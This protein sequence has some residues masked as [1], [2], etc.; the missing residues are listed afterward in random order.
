MEHVEIDWSP[1]NETGPVSPR[2]KFWIDELLDAMERAGRPMRVDPH[3]TRQ[4]LSNVGFTE[5]KEELIR[6]PVNGGSTNPFEIDIGRWFNLCLHK[7][8]MALSLA[9]LCRH[10]HWTPDQISALQSEVLQEI[11]D[12]NNRTFLKL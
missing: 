5:I 8:F 3:H 6:V 4:M 1:E 10:K 2:L 12:R 11:G 9:P 7:G